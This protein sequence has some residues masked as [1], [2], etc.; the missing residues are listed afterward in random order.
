MARRHD[1]GRCAWP[2]CRNTEL[3]LSWLGQP[4]CHRHWSAVCEITE[5]GDEGYAEAYEKLGIPQTD[6]H[7]RT[8]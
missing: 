7:S 1:Q 8:A 2:R 5:R 6:A 4:L 3:A